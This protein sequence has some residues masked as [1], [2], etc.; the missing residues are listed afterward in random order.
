[1]FAV[2]TFD[3]VPNVGAVVEWA[4][5][6]IFT[7]WVLSFFVDLIPAMRRVRARMLERHQVGTEPML[8]SGGQS[9]TRPLRYSAPDKE[10]YAPAQNF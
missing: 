4:I 3:N 2:C 9:N 1:M 8:M 6:F 10:V 7:A 5:A